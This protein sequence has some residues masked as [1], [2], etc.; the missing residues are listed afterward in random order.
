MR[1]RS[2]E[3]GQISITTVRDGPWVVVT[4]RDTGTG[5]PPEIR[6]RVFDPFFT[7]KPVGRGTG[8]GLAIARSI[9]VDKHR[10]QISFESEVGQGT[11]FVI[12]LP[13]QPLEG[14]PADGR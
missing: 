1:D 12:R 13:I 3:K 14:T 11:T 7:T 10:G 4:I 2:G 5:I 6:E 9:I 8:Q